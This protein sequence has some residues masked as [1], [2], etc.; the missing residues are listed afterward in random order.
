MNEVDIKL[1]NLTALNFIG[2]EWVRG[3]A[4]ETEIISPY[5]GQACGKTYFSNSDDVDKA[6]KAALKNQKDWAKTPL[7]SRTAVMFK[8]RDILL[9]DIDTISNVTALECGKTFGEAKAGIMKGVEVLEY[10]LSLQNSDLGG[11]MEVSRGVFCDYKREALGVVASITPFNFPAMVP[12]WT[13][14]IA[15]VLGNAY[16]WKP[17]EKTPLTSKYI[18]DAFHEAGLPVGLLTVV[19][20]AQAA[21]E[22]IIDHPAV[23]AIAFVGSTKVAQIVYGRATSQG[24]RALCLGGAKN[25]IILLP[26]A[27]LEVTGMG[28]SDSFTGCAGQ[29]CMAASVLLAVGDVA[30]HI[31]KIKERAAS[32][33][34]G[35]SMGAIITKEQL[36]FLNNA[37]EQAVSDGATLLIDGRNAKAPANCEGGYWL[38]PTILDNVKAE[39]EAVVRELFG[40]I[41]AIVR[42]SNITEAIKIQNSS[43]YGNAASVFT[44]SGPMAQYVA[45]LAECGMFGVNI[46]VPVP[47]EPF[48][49]GGVKSSKFGYGDI[50]GD[51]SLNFW[52]NVKKIT[53][54]WELQSDATWMS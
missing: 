44:S 40:P 6:V 22:G 3:S 8:F 27:D 41:L 17:S 34:L 18:A 16:V 7:K 39:S 1:D 54:K 47:R 46:G 11:R 4:G 10:A 49:F 42:C 13:I 2:G 33:V 26:D 28:I 38:G 32:Q 12:M 52:T 19:Q 48:S 25:H 36:N 51:H 29:R 5:T 45:D 9:R 43:E 31:T 14:P 23:K 24:K 21:V 15:I 30:Q 35:D 50:T 53:T 37:I 20:G